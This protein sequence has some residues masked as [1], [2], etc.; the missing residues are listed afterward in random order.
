MLNLG[1]P[2]LLPGFK[3]TTQPSCLSLNRKNLFSAFTF[4]RFYYFIFEPSAQGYCLLPPSGLANWFR[5]KYCYFARHSR[6]DKIKG[7]GIHQ[8]RKIS[9]YIGL[10][11][12]PV[13]VTGSGSV[14]NQTP[15]GG[16]GADRL[17]WLQRSYPH[18]AHVWRKQRWGGRARAG[19]GGGRWRWRRR[20]DSVSAAV[21]SNASPSVTSE[22]LVK[23]MSW[24]GRF[25]YY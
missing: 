17:D 21:I 8:F 20:R 25:K 5:A 7:G 2:R 11:L 22:L 6:V 4:F 15:W 24:N 19:P 1:L 9:V 10:G 16:T 14:T 23:W 12:G 13:P 3:W 18:G